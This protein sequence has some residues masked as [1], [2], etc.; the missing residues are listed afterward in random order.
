ML[1]WKSIS[2][3]TKLQHHGSY[4]FSLEKPKASTSNPSG[5]NTNTSCR[6]MC[7]FIFFLKQNKKSEIL[8]EINFY[9]DTMACSPWAVLATWLNLGSPKKR[10]ENE[11]NMRKIK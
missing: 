5:H 2:L 3:C 4:K 7:H 1:R 11:F 10:Q 6:T 8:K 9:F